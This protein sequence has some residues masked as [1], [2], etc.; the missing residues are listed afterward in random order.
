MEMYNIGETK[1][2]IYGIDVSHWNGMI[3][4][5]RVAGSGIRF[6]M[7]KCITDDAVSV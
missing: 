1:E 4:W 5:K 2:P 7:I 3:D 6:A